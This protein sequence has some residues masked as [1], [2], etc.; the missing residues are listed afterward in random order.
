MQKVLHPA[1]DFCN[2]YLSLCF[3]D[4]LAAL[5]AIQLPVTPMPTKMLVLILPTVP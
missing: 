2:G 5:P 1:F 4:K 3:I